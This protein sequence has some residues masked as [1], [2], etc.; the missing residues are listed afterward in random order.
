MLK[1]L[2]AGLLLRASLELEDERIDQ[3]KNLFRAPRSIRV[4]AGQSAI[5]S[6]DDPSPVMNGYWGGEHG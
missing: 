6:F 5:A 4:R 1:P 2:Y 3:I